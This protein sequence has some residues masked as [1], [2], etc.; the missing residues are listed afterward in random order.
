[1][2][3]VVYKETLLWYDAFLA[4]CGVQD[5]AMRETGSSFLLIIDTSFI[6]FTLEP[7]PYKLKKVLYHLFV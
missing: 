1:M 5:V 4:G 6:P 7:V 2:T 3:I